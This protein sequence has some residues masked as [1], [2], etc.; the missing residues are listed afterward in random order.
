MIHEAYAYQIV[1]SPKFYF[2]YTDK[3]LLGS[4]EKKSSFDGAVLFEIKNH[5][6]RLQPI[7]NKLFVLINVTTSKTFGKITIAGYGPFSKVIFE[8]NDLVLRWISKSVF[9]IHWQW[10]KDKM[11]VL[12]TIEN[13]DIG[14]QTGI[15]VSSDYFADTDILIMI[16]VYLRTKRN[17]LFFKSLYLL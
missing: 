7:N 2:V 11:V 15:I 12:E 16:G 14:K 9:A 3:V 10:Q 5:H 6:F 17:T 8:Y 13:F 4:I 1:N